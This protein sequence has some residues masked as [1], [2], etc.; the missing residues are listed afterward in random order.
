MF[1]S[2]RGLQL[3]LRSSELHG[4]SNV[5]NERENWR[6]IERKGEK[7]RKTKIRKGMFLTQGQILRV[8]G[9]TISPTS[10]DEKSLEIAGYLFVT[11]SD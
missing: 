6:D 9:G 8:S 1:Q 10:G 11:N 5:E 4:E 3:I 2:L 7:E